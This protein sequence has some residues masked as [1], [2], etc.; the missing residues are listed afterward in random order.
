MRW[1]TGRRSRNIED[2]RGAKSSFPGFPSARGR[3]GLKRGGG[4]SGG[5]ILIIIVIGLLTGQ[6]P[7]QMLGMIAGGGGSSY[8][9]AES[10][11]VP[12]NPSANDEQADFV[13]AVLA[14]TEDAWQAL[15]SQAGS[16]YQAP[17]LVLYNNV[18]K[19]ACGLG[20]SASGPFYC[21]ADSKVYLDLGFFNEFKKHGALY[22]SRQSVRS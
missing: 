21:P 18:T 4:L 16:N 15:F 3:R 20:Q 9:V 19:T 11:G 17:Q 14:D 7:L 5:V 8:P 10:Q 2:R 1:K 6:N 12:L 22:R 13:S